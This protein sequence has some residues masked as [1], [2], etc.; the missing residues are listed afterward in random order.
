MAAVI[1]LKDMH[2]ANMPKTMTHNIIGVVLAGGLS[3]R[4]G[5]DKALMQ[6]NGSTLLEHA[7]HRLQSCGIEQIYVSG[8]Y[9][10]YACIIDQTQRM[11]P[12]GG[13]YSVIKA[14]DTIDTDIIFIPVDMP[15]LS[16]KILL[17]LIHNQQQREEYDVSVFK[18][19]PLPILLKLS[20]Q[21]VE[22]LERLCGSS[23]KK[24]HAIYYFINQLNAQIIDVNI[25]LLP[26]FENVNTIEQWEKLG[27]I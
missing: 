3:S 2:C 12:L 8:Q 11:G 26:C 18:D 4:M 6:Y 1:G 23:N 17:E 10:G 13:I 15:L 24:H 27:V 19:Y 14:L 7:V 5:Q 21:V 20:S 16:H 22:V 9:S 25:K